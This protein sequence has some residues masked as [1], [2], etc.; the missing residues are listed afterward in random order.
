MPWLC[1]AGSCG[2]MRGVMTIR[3]NTKA[4]SNSKSKRR[5]N[6][7]QRPLREMFFCSVFFL[8][9]SGHAALR[10]DDPRVGTGSRQLYAR[11]GTERLKKMHVCGL[12]SSIAAGAATAVIRCVNTQRRC[13]LRA[14]IHVQYRARLT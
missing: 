14:D 13:V 9:F 11:H 2:S 12:G 6:T 8:F 4:T 5:W 3:S 10:A 7:C 1:S